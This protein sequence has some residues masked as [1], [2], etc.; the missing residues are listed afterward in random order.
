ML[1]LEELEGAV[2]LDT[3]DTMGEEDHSCCDAVANDKKKN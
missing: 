3:D 1:N 2:L